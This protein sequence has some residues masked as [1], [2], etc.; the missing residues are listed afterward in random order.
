MTKRALV[1]EDDKV[2]SKFLVTYLE[3]RGYEVVS[4]KNGAEGLRAFLGPQSFD[5]VLL[6]L[7]MPEVS[8]WDFLRVIN[9]LYESG[10]MTSESKIIVQT[11]VNNLD[12]LNRISDL[13]CVYSV[14]RKPLSVEMLALAIETAPA[15]D[16][17][18]NRS[19]GSSSVPS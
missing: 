3:K 9:N 10:M 1:V 11:A 5:V 19:L 12:E 2:S 6:D 13:S 16:R 18:L 14:L 17:T 15:F 7:M 8:G 4:A